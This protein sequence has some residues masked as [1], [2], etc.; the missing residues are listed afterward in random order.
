MITPEQ[1]SKIKVGDKLVLEMDVKSVQIFSD[2]DY[3]F[4]GFVFRND[5][6]GISDTK[7]KITQII[8]AA[9]DWGTVKPGDAFTHREVGFS[10]YIGPDLNDAKRVWVMLENDIYPQN[11]RKIN[12][13]PE[14]DKDAP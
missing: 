1:M 11:V 4:N 2:G 10:R 14:H 8:P 9:F 6:V 3:A 13:T 7:Y 12:L 5:G